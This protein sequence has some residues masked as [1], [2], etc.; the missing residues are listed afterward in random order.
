[1]LPNAKANVAATVAATSEGGFICRISNN[2][3][4]I[5]A[6]MDLWSIELGEA[7]DAPGWLVR[8]SSYI[9]NI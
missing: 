7:S 2:F 4:S 6:L 5:T 9:D 3:L 8:P 1:M